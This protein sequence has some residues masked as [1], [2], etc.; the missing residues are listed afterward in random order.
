MMKKEL[1]YYLSLPYQ[2]EVKVIPDE[3]GGGFMARLPQFGILGIIGNGESPEE[4][5]PNLD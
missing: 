1:E 5:L 3:E 4:A 2:I